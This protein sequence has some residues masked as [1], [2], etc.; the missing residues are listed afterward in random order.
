MR[1]TVLFVA[2]GALVAL[3][4]APAAAA[5]TSQERR[6]RSATRRSCGWSPDTSSCEPDKPYQPIDVNVLF[7]EPTVA[8][9]GPWSSDVVKIAPEAKD[10]GPRLFGYH[11]DFPGNALQPGCDYPRLGEPD[12]RGEDA[13]GLRARRDRPGAPG[14]ARAAVLALLRLQRLEQPP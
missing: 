9:T 2:L 13:D 14:Q 5:T 7:G 11:L 12:Y 3:A 1:A 8:L 4:I 6:S 10:L